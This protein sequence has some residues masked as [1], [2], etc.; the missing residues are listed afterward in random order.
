MSSVGTVCLGKCDLGCPVRIGKSTFD[1]FGSSSLGLGNPDRA[2]RVQGAEGNGLFQDGFAV[3]DGLDPEPDER[4]GVVPIDFDDAE[5][6]V[7]RS[8]S[9]TLAV[10]GK[11]P[12]LVERTGG[13]IVGRVAQYIVG[14]AQFRPMLISACEDDSL[15]FGIL[16][17]SIKTV[18]LFRKF[19]P[20]L[21]TMLVGY[22]LDT[23]TEHTQGRGD[24]ELVFQPLPLS[25]AK[26]GSVRI[27]LGAPEIPA[28]EENELDGADA[29]AEDATVINAFA[30]AARI[31]SGSAPEIEEDLLRF[32][33]TDVLLPRV[34][35]S[36][37]V[38]IPGRKHGANRLE[39]FESFIV[40]QRLVFGSE[41]VHVGRVSVNI[42]PQPD[43]GMRRCL[44][45]L[46]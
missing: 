22:N 1:S 25:R 42:V 36:V 16:D 28:V 4:I 2:P 30:R 37:V 46:V 12:C 33:F 38:I 17:K 18:P 5:I 27:L 39:S 23:A 10:H 11:R 29:F 3:G 35:E 44:H 32:F 6:G 26:H 31:Q 19:T 7:G 9:Q 20:S 34:I 13:E 24:F 14:A 15:G 41:N 43:E 21:E 45:D 8:R 40:A